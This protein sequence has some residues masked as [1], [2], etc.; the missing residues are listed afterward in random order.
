MADFVADLRA[1]TPTGAA[2]RAVPVRSELALTVDD[3]GLR[4]Q[5]GAL[6]Q[7]GR[8][9]E[10]L[11]GLARGLGKPGHML[12]LAYQRLDAASQGL[13]RGLD[14][15]IQG[16]A[17]AV[18]RLALKLVH[19]RE[20]LRAA[21]DQLGQRVE[22][23]RL[24]A[25]GLLRG[26]ARDWQSLQ[27]PRRLS[28]A[29]QR[30]LERDGQALA[31]V[32]ALMASYQA[33]DK[34]ALERGYARVERGDGSLLTQAASLVPGEILRLVFADGAGQV[35]ALEPGAGQSQS[36]PGTASGQPQA[37]AKPEASSA[38]APAAAKKSPKK[39]DGQGWLL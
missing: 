13:D 24:A 10:L 37:S 5:R 35:Q 3:L 19:P 20:A 25:T 11:A 30:R 14:T 31:Q 1:P 36:G 39:D 21:G 2:E 9:A 38:N 34:R 7:T 33:V 8:R 23:L 32:S 27:A 4:L 16:R 26:A 29:V 18:E 17:Q 15:Q 6:S 22:R 28:Q 12:D